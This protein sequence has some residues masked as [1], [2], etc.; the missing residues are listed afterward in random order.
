MKYERIVSYICERPWA[1]REE[2][3]RA[4]AEL[5]ALRASG[6]TLT[7]EEIQ[8]RI[9]ERRDSDRSSSAGGGVVAL[10]PVMGVL[11]HRMDMF[12]EYSGGTST[13]RLARVVREASMD[14]SVEAIVLDIDSEGGIVEGIPELW[15]EIYQVRDKKKIIA[16]ANAMAAS[17]AYWIASAADEIVVTPSGSVGS[18]GVLHIHMEESKAIEEAGIGVTI[19]RAGKY[20]SDGNPFE[21]LSDSA[22]EHIEKRVSEAYN[23]FVRDVAKGRGVKAADVRNGYGQGHVVSAQEAKELGMVDR[24]ESLDS[25]VSRLVGK[26]G[27]KSAVSFALDQGQELVATAPFRKVQSLKREIEILE[28]EKNT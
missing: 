11:S 27:R 23:M 1:I 16:V 17:A 22:K 8:A 20:K 14:E 10:I 19:T 13:E 24:I 3:L 18:I 6:L 12:S 26:R 2:K 5:V 28:L 15:Q 25:T 4:I 21:P 9:G 7:T